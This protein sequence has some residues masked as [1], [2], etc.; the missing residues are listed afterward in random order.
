MLKTG[1]RQRCIEWSNKALAMDPEEP[2]TLY[3]VACNYS[4]LGRIEESIECLERA[5]K[6]GYRHKQWL[7]HDSDLDPLRGHARFQELL[8]S[9]GN[10]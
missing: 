2:L 8:K 9:L 3:N 6:F 10:H 5:V 7:E 4:L 1:E